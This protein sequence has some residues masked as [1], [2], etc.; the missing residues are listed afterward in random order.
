[1]AEAERGWF[2]R[3]IAGFDLGPL[4]YRKERP[5]DDFDALEDTPIAEVFARYVAELDACRQVAPRA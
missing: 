3:R 2:R 4:Y 1:M 5:D